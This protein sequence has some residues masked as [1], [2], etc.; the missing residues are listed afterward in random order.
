MSTLLEVVNEALAF[1]GDTPL[2]NLDSNLGKFATRAVREATYIFV[3]QVRPREFITSQKFNVVNTTFDFETPD[4]TIPSTAQQIL[5]TY[6]FP[7]NTTDV[8]YELRCIPL[9]KLK[10]NYGVNYE[11]NL[12]FVTYQLPRPVD[13][14]VKY[15]DLPDLTVLTD[16]STFPFP[17][18][19]IGTITMLAA[20]ILSQTQSD[21]S[22]QSARL[23]QAAQQR[24]VECRTRYGGLNKPTTWRNTAF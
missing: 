6:Y 1:S 12:G 10:N 23:A 19:Y 2:V 8:I 3:N 13:V 18:R 24:L 16:S 20:S 4:F 11:G 7:T 15:V 14:F 17:D 9:E 22:A 5:T 21:D